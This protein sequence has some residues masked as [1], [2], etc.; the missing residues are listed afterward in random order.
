MSVVS[1]ILMACGFP[2]PPDI[3]TIHGTVRGLW[4]GTGGVALRLQAD[5]IDALLVISENGVFTFAE[6]P[7]TGT[8][9]TVTVATNPAQHSC[10]VED[11]ANG[12][13]ADSD[14]AKLSIACTGPA[15][16]TFS[17]PW[18]WIFDP[19]QE[20]QTFSGTIATQEVA[21]TI[22]GNS[23]TGARVGGS[24]ATIGQPTGTI[25][26]P[27]GTSTVPVALTANSGL[28]KMYEL[29]FERG[30]RILE[31]TTYGKASNT[32]EGD[33]LGSAIAISG[34]TLVIGSDFEASNATGINGNQFDNSAKESGGVYVFV[35]NGTMWAQQA[36]IKASNTGMFDHFGAAVALS[37]DTLAVGAPLEASNSTGINTG[38]QAD[39]GAFGAGAVYVFVRKNGNWT[40]QAYIK[41]S[42]TQPPLSN[43]ITS[44]GF[45]RS[46]ALSGDT[47]AVGALGEDS[48]STG[49]N[50]DQNNNNAQGAGAVYVFIRDGS[51]WSQ[52]AYIKAS[53]TGTGDSFGT[54][55]LS[56]DTL[57]VGA[58]GE[59]SKATG[60]NGDQADNS[61]FG[62]GA[63]Y[64]FVRNG[65]NWTQQAYIKASN[66]MALNAFGSPLA[67]S[68]D[69]LAVTALGEDSN[70]TGINGNQA[71]TSANNAGAVYVFA[72]HDSIWTQQVYIKPSNTAALDSFG[73]SLSLSGDMLAVGSPN[74]NGDATGVNGNQNDNTAFNGAG[75]V[76][77]FNFDGSKWAQR[78]YVKASNTGPDEFGR[79][80]AISSDTLVIAAPHESSGAV[81]IDPLNGQTDNSV[82][83]AGAF[84]IFR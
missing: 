72:R 47:L 60:V 42:N 58:I 54:V 32:G 49:V 16:I 53:N 52:Q 51:T 18:G 74:E 62:A 10:V 39:N 81:G 12:I 29:L 55:A 68:G 13:V 50:R 56:K 38:N 57:A 66:T 7:A 14:T 71:D 46:I 73:A 69:T 1:A 75:A 37:G 21:L 11:G 44:D 25:A 36:Y 8:S 27:L 34:D 80:A 40:Q 45:G 24:V 31:Q 9:Y 22:T 4:D 41:A 61:A 70:A 2:R 48:D 5:G 82:R 28:S 59:S 79:S 30:G 43:E 65:T 78:L 23:L 19:T 3:G 17:G 76:Y 83:D 6:A 26:L 63:V 35:R 67:I 77:V 20:T 33:V 84:Y 64:V 15:G